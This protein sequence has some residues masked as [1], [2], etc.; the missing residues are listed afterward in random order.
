MQLRVKS[1]S[2][3][4]Y[5]VI[6]KMNLTNKINY[7]ERIYKDLLESYFLSN[8]PGD[9]LISHG[10][11]HHRRV[12]EF[13]K[14][15][16]HSVNYKEEN[17]NEVFIEKLLIA[18]YLHDIGMLI[19]PG[20]KHG[21]HSR[22]LCKKFLE[23]NHLHKSD[24]RDVLHAIENHDD[25]KYSKSAADDE[26]QTIL[27]IA[28]DLDAFGYIG[29]YRYTEIFL[30]RGIPLASLG[31]LILENASNRFRNFSS[32]FTHFQDLIRK[33]QKRFEIL[34]KFFSEYNR[35]CP[36][37][38]F[39]DNRPSGH[40]GVIEIIKKNLEGDKEPKLNI[41]ESDILYN[42]PVIKDFFVKLQNELS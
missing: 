22:M 2:V 36:G 4:F 7:A 33:H 20:V 3:N 25:K 37:Y 27:S 32:S 9:K 23:K 35:M 1:C 5:I 34:F 6:I 41:I 39:G 31:N 26:L 16:L 14:E 19:D 29:I 28:D 13:A 8:Y 18:C 12:W 21:N 10:I 15:L 40:C 38:S 24:F 30:F 42:D 11:Y 17:H